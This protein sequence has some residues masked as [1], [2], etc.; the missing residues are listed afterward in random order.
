MQYEEELEFSLT[1]RLEWRNLFED[2][3]E[4]LEPIKFKD[5]IYIHPV[6]LRDPKIFRKNPAYVKE[7]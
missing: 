5:K 2:L 6:I 7:K 4:A 3:L 1:S